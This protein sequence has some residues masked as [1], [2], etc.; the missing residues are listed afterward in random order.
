MSRRIATKLTPGPIVEYVLSVWDPTGEGNAVLRNKLEMVQR[1]AARFV[2]HDWRTTSSNR[3]HVHSIF[4]RL[5]NVQGT[6]FT[7]KQLVKE[8]LL[9]LKQFTKLSELEDVDLPAI[10]PSAVIGQV[11]P[12]NSC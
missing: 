2:Y 5:D 4:I 6:K 1:E 8:E 11:S 7:L 9:S 10:T 12:V 3:H